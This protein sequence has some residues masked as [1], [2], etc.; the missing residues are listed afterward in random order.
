MAGLGDI[1]RLHEGSSFQLEKLYVESD[2][3]G[4]FQDDDEGREEFEF[5]KIR[6]LSFS[7]CHFNTAN[8]ACF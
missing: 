2:D 1:S 5:V 4:D 7:P 8:W 3:Q 6:L